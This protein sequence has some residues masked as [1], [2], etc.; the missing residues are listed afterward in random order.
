MYSMMNRNR[1]MRLSLLLLLLVVCC[2]GTA[3]CGLRVVDA[4]DAVAVAV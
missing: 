1:K 4:V 3:R 2:R